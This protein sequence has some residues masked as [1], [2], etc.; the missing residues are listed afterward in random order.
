MFLNKIYL[1]FLTDVDAGVE[2]NFC[3][4]RIKQKSVASGE[5]CEYIVNTWN[6]MNKT[7]EKDP[8]PRHIRNTKYILFKNMFSISNREI[9]EIERSF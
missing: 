8:R 1:V 3:A 4:V 7:K 6:D 2:R 5:S 9:V